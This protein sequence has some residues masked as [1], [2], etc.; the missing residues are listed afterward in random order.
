MAYKAIKDLAEV[1][2]P[3]GAQDNQLCDPAMHTEYR[4]VLGGMNW[5][6]SRTQ[7]TACYRFSRAASASAAPTIG[8]VKLLNKAVRMMQAHPVSL[9]F[10]PLKGPLR[11]IGYPDASYRNNSDKSSQRGQCI[12]LAEPH[13]GGQTHT[14]GSIGSTFPSF[15][16]SS[17]SVV[18]Q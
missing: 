9:V 14:C 15:P 11:L 18:C 3:R 8:D 6:Q 10:W 1:I 13:Q 7:F 17:T 5:L 4:S 12:F 2:V 16:R